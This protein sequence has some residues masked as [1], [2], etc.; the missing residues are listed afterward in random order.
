V[1]WFEERR[2]AEAAEEAGI[3]VFVTADQDISYQQNMEGRKVCIV[4]LS[5]NNWPVIKL[6]VAKIAAA[7]N[8]AKPGAATRVDCGLFT[9][10]RRPGPMGPTLG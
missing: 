1:E 4:Y 8:E 6:H 7:I 10:Q 5:A 3:G 2:I 9:R